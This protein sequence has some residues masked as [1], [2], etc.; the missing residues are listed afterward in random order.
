MSLNVPEIKEELCVFLR[1]QDILSTTQRGVTNTTK[2]GTLSSEDTITI[3][4]SDVKNIRSIEVASTSKSFG[5][6]YLVDYNNASGCVITF[7][8]N[9]TGDYT[10]DYDYGSD[11]I[12]PDFPR[13]FTENAEVLTETGWKKIKKTNLNEKIMTF[14]IEKEELEYNKINA[15][16][17]Q[18]YSGE[19][20]NID[21]QQ[22]NTTVTPNHEFVIRDGNNLKKIKKKQAKKLTIGNRIVRTGE[23]N[24]NTRYDNIILREYR[25]GNKK[26]NKVIQKEQKIDLNDF[27][28]LMGWYLSEGSIRNTKYHR[29]INIC[30]TK[31]E[32]VKNIRDLLERM[33]LRYSYGK[34]GNFSIYNRDL[35]K[36][37]LECG[38]GFLNKE[39]PLEIK[40]LPKEN[41]EYLLETLIKGDGTKKD[42]AK[43]SF[44]FY[45]CSEKL[46]DDFQEIA[47]KCGRPTRKWIKVPNPNLSKNKCYCVNIYGEKSKNARLFKKNMKK[48]DYSGKVYCLS[49]KNKTLLIRENGSTFI[50][51]NSDLSVSSYPR[52][53]V[54][55]M[56]IESDAFGIGGDSFISSVTFTIVVFDLKQNIIEDYISNIRSDFISNSKGFYYL[57]F[58]K[59]IGE[60]PILDSPEKNNEIMK[61]NIDFTSLFQVESN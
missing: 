33:K 52:I 53:A 34:D 17:E 22:L 24:P 32:G 59:P 40:M 14:N 48:I 58:V 10:V 41:L 49:T 50:S 16:I 12:Y 26:N 19:M 5:K 25:Y 60:G 11:S 47:V 9:Q 37:F 61:K 6:D 7:N 20:I 29:G 57:K 36:K 38:K 45:S 8:S 39:I 54:D 42:K 51:G 28:S 3:S 21:H 18:D 4:K 23:F 30:Q 43:D 35:V 44:T 31:K 55:I 56:N 2:T 1:N 46:A 27:L 15:K 13:C